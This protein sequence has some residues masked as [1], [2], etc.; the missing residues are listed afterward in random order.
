MSRKGTNS[1]ILLALRLLPQVKFSFINF[2]IPYIVAVG[3][4]YLFYPSS[5]G[6]KEILSSVLSNLMA[7]NGAVLGLILGVFGI[8][9][10]VESNQRTLFAIVNA[11]EGGKFSFYK[12]KLVTIFKMCFWVFICSFLLMV[13][14]VLL[15]L[16]G[17]LELLAS[18]VNPDFK[19]PLF[20]CV[21]AWLQSKLLIEL[22]I[23]IFTMYQRSIT[24]ARALA[25]E[26]K[27]KPF[28]N[29]ID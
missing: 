28:D 16:S 15:S 13:M 11:P 14:Y 22:K 24:E 8:Y 20:V 1:I 12:Y 9:G 7:F 23:Y 6:S 29:S 27:Q 17:K 3:F 25:L 26:S 4:A 5:A 18:L 10:A 21:V 19:V 2:A